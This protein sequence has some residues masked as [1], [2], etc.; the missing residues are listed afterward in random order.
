MATARAR[1]R[2]R[3]G[4]AE[5]WFVPSPSC[6]PELSPQQKTSPSP[7][8]AQERALLGTKP[9]QEPRRDGTVFL[10]GPAGV[11]KTEWAQHIARELKMLGSFRVLV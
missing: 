9:A 4:T 7:V 1:D 10:V 3:T 5:D 6:P 2:T 11:G 8:T